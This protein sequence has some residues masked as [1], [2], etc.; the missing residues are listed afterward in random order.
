MLGYL[1][2][3]LALLAG[4]IKGYCGKKSGG[5]LVLASDAMLVNTV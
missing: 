2:L 1:F 5:T 3:A 4:V